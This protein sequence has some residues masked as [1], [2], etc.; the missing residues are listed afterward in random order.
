M[1][2]LL[3]LLSWCGRPTCIHKPVLK[4]YLHLQRNNTVTTLSGGL[5]GVHNWD[6]STVE[7]RFCLPV[8]IK[9]GLWFKGLGFRV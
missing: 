2:K 1:H 5:K 8:D 3:F 6:E 4:L 9:V 7:T